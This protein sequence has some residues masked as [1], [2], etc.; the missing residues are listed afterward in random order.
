[1]TIPHI[2]KRPGGKYL[3][4]FYNKEIKREQYIRCD[5]LLCGVRT[6]DLGDGSGQ[7]TTV[8]LLEAVC[9]CVVARLLFLV[10]ENMCAIHSNVGSYSI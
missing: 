10:V 1:M 4:S 7:S 2:Q 5:K 3:W 9:F 6:G 8:C